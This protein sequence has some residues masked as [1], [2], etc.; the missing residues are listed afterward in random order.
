MKVL[1]EVTAEMAIYIRGLLVIYAKH[2]DMNCKL[3]VY[4]V[5]FSTR[6]DKSEV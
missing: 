4:N 3:R 1:C 2:M 5:G 6:W